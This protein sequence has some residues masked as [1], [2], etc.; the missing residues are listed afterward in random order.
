MIRSNWIY[1][2]Y[3]WKTRGLQSKKKEGK[4]RNPRNF[5]NARFSF[6]RGRLLHGPFPPSGLVYGCVFIFIFI[7]FIRQTRAVRK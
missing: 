1:T 3:T 4:K 5:I 2:Y 7:F 6:D